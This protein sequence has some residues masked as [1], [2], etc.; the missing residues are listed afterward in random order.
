MLIAYRLI[1]QTNY[2]I[3]GNPQLL[4]LHYLAINQ[5][6]IINEHKN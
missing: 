4:L 2:T 5:Q 6:L 3:S 1:Y